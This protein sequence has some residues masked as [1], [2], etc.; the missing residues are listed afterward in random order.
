MAGAAYGQQETGDAVVHS[1]FHETNYK[2]HGILT[3]PHKAMHTWRNKKYWICTFDAREER[4]PGNITSLGVEHVNK[5]NI[6]NILHRRP[7]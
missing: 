2:K 5:K 1:C 3:V 6:V 4:K 7:N